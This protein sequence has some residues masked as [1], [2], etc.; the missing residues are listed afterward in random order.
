MKN[1]INTKTP[2]IGL[3]GGTFDPIHLGHLLIAQAVYETFP[4]EQVIFIPAQRNPLKKY[5][6]IASNE[7]RASMIRL[8][9]EGDPRF[10]FSA[11]ELD[12]E[13]CSYTI[14][15]VEHIQHEYP[16]KAFYWI[17][18]SDQMDTLHQW[19]RIKD[20]AKQIEFISVQRPGFEQYPKTT[21]PGLK[22]H[23]LTYHPFSVSATQIR[24]RIKN[25]L[26][27]DLFLPPKVSNYL[28]SNNPYL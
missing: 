8:A 1:F 12:R 23:P 20:L 7:E 2:C 11:C 14:D 9:I 28:K 18:G 25:S 24:E 19:F 21:V 17:L 4:I 3:L 6:S 10:G 15:T 13:D 5:Q 26:P 27:I 16:D 22:I